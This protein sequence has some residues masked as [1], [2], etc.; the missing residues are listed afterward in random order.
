MGDNK[1]TRKKIEGQL[2]ARAEHVKKFAAYPSLQD[3]AFA[4]RTIQNIDKE[5]EALYKKLGEKGAKLA[6]PVMPKG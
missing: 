6:V 1:E 5:L 4:L 3:K 2:R